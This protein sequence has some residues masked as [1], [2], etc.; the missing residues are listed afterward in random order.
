MAPRITLHRKHAIQERREPGRLNWERGASPRYPLGAQHSSGSHAL[1]QGGA[2][3]ASGRA[4][5]AAG[6]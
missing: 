5:G 1:P 2:G 4:A 3:G 6:P